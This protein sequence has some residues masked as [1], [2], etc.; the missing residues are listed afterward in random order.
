MLRAVLR[1]TLGWIL[2]LFFRRI[3]LSGAERVPAQGPVIFA[4]NH[5]NGLVDGLLLLT[6]APRP[7]SFLAKAPLF[8]LPVI[9]WV[10]RSLETIPVYRRQDQADVSQ[11]RATFERAR[12]LLDRGGTI[13]IAP[14]GASHSDPSLRPI[15]TGAARIALGATLGVPVAIVPV[16]LFYTEKATFRSAAHLSFGEPVL[17]NPAPL[18]AH[19]EPPPPMVDQVTAQ[20][21][22]ALTDAVL[23]A[24]HHEALTLATRTERLLA[25]AAGDPRSRT[26]QEVRA[27][28]RLLLEGYRTMKLAEPERLDGLIRRIDRLESAF[29]SA[30]L[31]PGHA[32]P[33]AVSAQE[34]LR[35]TVWLVFRIAIFLP[36]AVPGLVLHYPAYW[37][38]G[39]L[40]ARYAGTHDDVLATAKI[41]GA[42]LLYPLTWLAA[43]VT[44]GLVWGAPLG[45]ATGFLAPL[46]GYAALKLVER[47]DRF[48]TGTRAIGLYLA[49]PEQVRRLT[50]ERDR[51][52]T[53]LAALG[54]SLGLLT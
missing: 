53:D 24:D 12:A 18:D 19:G 5:P 16:G 21:E 10:I 41:I 1:T 32:L 8:D 4:I 7:V 48:L 34:L 13:A 15:K 30:N 26:V 36:L 49:R 31:D 14:E 33:R 20:I 23:Q 54:K 3:E 47:F 22:R 27:T 17:V 25:A 40:A 9:G 11:N 46:S 50:L 45:A 2:G 42:A 44:I 38:I 43:C 35:G 37:T 6:Y 39:R 28:Q 51:L 52:R 29:R